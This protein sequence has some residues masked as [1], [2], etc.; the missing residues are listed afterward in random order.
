M[1]SP[2]HVTEFNNQGQKPFSD[3]RKLHRGE[4]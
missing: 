2:D 3:K 1:R 4:K